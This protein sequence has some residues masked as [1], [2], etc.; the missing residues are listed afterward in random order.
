MTFFP[1]HFLGLAGMP[2]RYS[3]YPDSFTAGNLVSSFGA[4]IR[5]LG[6]CIFMFMVVEALR[7]QRTVLARDAPVTAL[8][9]ED[10]LPLDFHNSIHTLHA[11]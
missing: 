6:V 8:E 2:R 4:V 9:W 10:R 7:V 1:Q 3:D 5:F 11:G